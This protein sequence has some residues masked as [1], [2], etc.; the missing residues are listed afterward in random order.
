M[1]HCL[2]DQ[3]D[4]VKAVHKPFHSQCE[5]VELKLNP[6]YVTLFTHTTEPQH[7]SGGTVASN[8]GAMEEHNYE[9][10]EGY[11]PSSDGIVL[12]ENPAYITA[13]MKSADQADEFE[14][15]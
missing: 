6:A 4:K 3:R 14:Y 2:Q 1:L 7:V 8:E 13:E 10:C 5:N 9:D 15:L 11:V 12:T